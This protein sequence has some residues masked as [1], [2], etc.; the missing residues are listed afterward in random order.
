MSGGASNPKIV[1]GAWSEYVYGTP[2][3]DRIDARGGDDT[4][5]GH[6]GNDTITGGA[7]SDT[8]V[9]DRLYQDWCGGQDMVTDFAI[10]PSAHDS[11]QFNGWGTFVAEPTGSLYYGETFTT[12]LGHTLTVALGTNGGTCLMW[13]TGDCFDLRAVAPGG[14]DASWIFSS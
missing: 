10:K 5:T 12:D 13:D 7:G 9:M 6:C 1:G 3:S 11:I 14:I 2:D 4:I 8:F